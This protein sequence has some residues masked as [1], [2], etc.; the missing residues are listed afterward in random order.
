MPNIGIE[1]DLQRWD[2]ILTSFVVPE[3]HFPIKVDF[4]RSFGLALAVAIVVFCL[5]RCAVNCP[6]CLSEEVSTV[7]AEIRLYRNR[8][9]TMSYPPMSPSPDIHVCRDCGWSEFSIPRAWLSAGWLR[10]I[11]VP[12]APSVAAITSSMAAAV[13]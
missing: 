1:P 13:S 7:P 4:S 12:A 9:R 11:N 6:K 8:P 3:L 5:S 10:P 2:R